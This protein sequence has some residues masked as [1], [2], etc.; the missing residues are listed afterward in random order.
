[1]PISAPISA[2][3]TR[4]WTAAAITN[5]GDGALLAAGPLLIASITTD[6]A[7]VAA[8]MFA[9]Q[10]PWLLFALTSGA[11][12]DRLPRRTL[13]LAVNTARG[14]TLGLLA[15]A[16]TVA[17]PQLWLIYVVLF[18]LGTGETLADATYGALVADT[19]PPDQLGRANTRIFLTFS[20]GNQ[21]AGPPLGALLFAAGAAL[22]FGF[23]ALVFLLTVLILFRLNTSPPSTQDIRGTSLR[24]E[25]AEGLRWLWHHRGLRVLAAC[26]LVM[27]LAGVGVFALWV[28]YGTQRLGLTETGYGLFIAAGAVGAITGSWVYGRLEQWFGMVT[29]L[30]AGLVVEAATYA[31][32]ALTQNPWVAGLTMAVFGVHAVVWGS[33]ATTVRQLATPSALLGRVGSVYQLAS[34]GGAALGALLG[35]F[36]AQRFGLLAPFWIAFAAVAA[37]TALCWRRLR[38]VEPATSQ[39]SPRHSGP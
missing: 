5:L 26:I 17:E 19:V 24:A 3:F 4:L 15:I 16:I 27:N 12:V 29:L 30:R 38:D 21:L 37:M 36:V 14:A 31:A 8:A 35:G 34:V 25:V 11:L 9:Q 2:D 32:L 22:P 33:V 28:L 1:M 13:L 10:L 39:G 20:L 23:K 7:A 6:P 18:L